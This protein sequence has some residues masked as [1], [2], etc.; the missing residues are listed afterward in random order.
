MLDMTVYNPVHDAFHSTRNFAF[1]GELL[2]LATNFP[3][4]SKPFG[5]SCGRW[6]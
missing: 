2:W 4:R 5:K 3:A 6:R 1:L